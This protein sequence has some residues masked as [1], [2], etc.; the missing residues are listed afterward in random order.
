MHVRV[1]H[2][3]RGHPEASEISTVQ[4]INTKGQ[5]IPHSS[6]I[7]PRTKET[8]KKLSWC[9]YEQLTD[10]LAIEVVDGQLLSRDS[11][12]NLITSSDP[13]LDLLH[14]C[15]NILEAHIVESS[16]LGGID[17]NSHIIN[18]VG[19]GSN[20]RNEKPILVTVDLH[21][22]ENHHLTANVQR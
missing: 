16:D 12:A 10:V 3:S 17:H 19:A 4:H 15:P 18:Q 8:V 6:E 20:G 2:G 1:D 13:T 9:T 22:L 7:T 5:I 14:A 21:G 11:L